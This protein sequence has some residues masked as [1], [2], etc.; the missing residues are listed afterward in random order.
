M[1]RAVAR[2]VV[3]LI[4]VVLLGASAVGVRAE[5]R[6]LLDLGHIPLPSEAV[7]SNA[8]MSTFAGGTVPP[9]TISFAD[10]MQRLRSSLTDADAAATV[11]VAAGLDLPAI[12]RGY[13]AALI[14]AG[15]PGAALIMLLRA[16]E[17][18]PGD[19][20]T[21]EM[22]AG[23]VISMG[24]A[25]E[26]RAILGEL[27]R[28]GPPDEGGPVKGEVV[29]SVLSGYAKFLNGDN[30]GALRD[31]DTALEGDPFLPEAERAI[32]VVQLKLGNRDA[33]VATAERGLW[34]RLP[35]K[36]LMA[37]YRHKD[38]EQV[39]PATLGQVDRDELSY[40]QIPAQDL[41]DLS[42][43]RP[44]VLPKYPDPTTPEEMEVWR[45]D[46]YPNVIQRA[47][48][49][50]Y[51]MILPLQPIRDEMAKH[52]S[53]D[54]NAHLASV[55]EVRIGRFR[56]DE[57]EVMNL[58]EL[59]QKE[60][61]AMQAAILQISNEHSKAT[62][63]PNM[64]CGD[65]RSITTATLAKKRTATEPYRRTFASFFRLDGYYATALTAVVR[66]DAYRLSLEVWAQ[67]RAMRYWMQYYGDLQLAYQDF[68]PAEC[69]AGPADMDEEPAIWDR[70]W[71]GPEEDDC[72]DQLKGR[73]LD[74]KL[75]KVAAKAAG[76]G[77]SPS[78]AL[79]F[80]MGLSCDAA[81]LEMSAE[82][83]NIPWIGSLS[84]FAQGEYSRAAGTTVYSGFKAE[85]ELVGGVQTGLYG[86]VTGDG[87]YDAGAKGSLNLKAGLDKLTGGLIPADIILSQ[88]EMKFPVLPV[89][90]MPP[91]PKIPIGKP[92]TPEDMRPKP[93]VTSPAPP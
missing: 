52:F 79:Q 28:L 20:D 29:R 50:S 80:S 36:R 72:P 14:L 38:T 7:D 17:L 24:L 21:L 26:G 3:R 47:D 35:K 27:E 9:E 2:V 5:P 12:A 88:E 48:R 62:S 13:A 77:A 73:G 59:A 42:H 16:D 81:S 56:L 8:S 75:D 91:A 63:K 67:S 89:A 40:L 93:S 41:Y 70:E 74:I 45:N 46:Y 19:P 69:L 58:W 22:I 68:F 1:D 25:N 34:A 11:A 86:T 64:T 31:L 32:E 4:G 57:P 65:W 54:V 55:I 66:H 71:V 15:K 83:G 76:T 53:D 37:I 78:S 43:G 49:I 60:R 33:A 23:L 82:L 90:W 39:T 85:N 87:Y 92:L 10:A 61:E 6:S 44:G 18:K 30:E 51:E 84:I